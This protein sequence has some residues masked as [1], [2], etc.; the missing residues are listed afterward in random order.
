[1]NAEE[2]RSQKP[3]QTGEPGTMYGSRLL[4]DRDCLLFIGEMLREVAAQ[5]AEKNAHA[6]ARAEKPKPPELRVAIRSAARRSSANKRFYVGH[7]GIE[8]EECM[9]P[10]FIPM[11][12]QPHW[13]DL[14][15]GDTTTGRL[16]TFEDAKITRRQ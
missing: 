8:A 15:V 9:M 1:M 6:R 16:G 5:L 13:Q 14:A 3:H 4:T 11:P 10:D 12:G 7:W 2:I